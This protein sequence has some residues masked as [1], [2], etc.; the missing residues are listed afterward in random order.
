[1]DAFQ[2]HEAITDMFRVKERCGYCKHP[3]EDD[4]FIIV[5]DARCCVGCQDRFVQDAEYDEA[6]A[7]QEKIERANNSQWLLAP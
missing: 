4:D 6:M 5:G 7:H 2:M 1:M 3:I